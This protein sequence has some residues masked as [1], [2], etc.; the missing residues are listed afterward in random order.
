MTCVQIDAQGAAHWMVSHLPQQAYGVPAGAGKDWMGF[1]LHLGVVVDTAALL[2]AVQAI[3]LN[4]EPAETVARVHAALVDFTR[5]GAPATAR[6]GFLPS[7]AMSFN[8]ENASA[9]APVSI[10][11]KSP[12][13]CT[14]RRDRPK[15]AS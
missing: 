11:P 7:R 12:S 10:S 13:S 9:V 8:D 15:A 4:R 3:D 2:H 5:C 14:K 6:C 1:R